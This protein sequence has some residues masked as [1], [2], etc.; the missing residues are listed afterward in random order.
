MEAS[1]R[2]VTLSLAYRTLDKRFPV[3]TNLPNQAALKLWLLIEMNQELDTCLAL[4]KTLDTTN[5]QE[6]GGGK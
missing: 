6:R 5:G 3:V 2:I 4:L 1:K